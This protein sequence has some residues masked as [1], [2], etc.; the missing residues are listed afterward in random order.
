[1]AKSSSAGSIPTSKNNTAEL[2]LDYLGDILVQPDNISSL[3]QM[4]AIELLL[5]GILVRLKQ[6]GSPVAVEKLLQGARSCPL[7]SIRKLAIQLL[8]EMASTS[9]DLASE[10]LFTLAIWD[11]EADAMQ[12]LKKFNIRS[13]SPDIQAVFAVLSHNPSE[14]RLV[15]PDFCLLTDFFLNRAT[16]NLQKRL[17]ANASALGY[18]S[19]I[20][21]VSASVLPS[22]ES[23]M[24]LHQKFESFQD[25]ER[26][27]AL[28]VLDQ[29]ALRGVTLAREAICQYFIDYEYQPACSLAIS[30]GYSPSLPVQAALFYFLAEQWQIYEYL[31]FNQKLI[32][33]AYETAALPLRKR[34]LLLSRYSGRTEWMSG[35]ST[36]SRQR[37]LW[38]MTDADWNLAIRNLLSSNNYRD[39]WRLAQLS[40]PIWSKQILS[41][42]LFASWRPD[43]QEERD[44]YLQLMELAHAISAQL[45]PIPLLHTWS[46]PSQEINSLA[47]SHDG[48][49]LAVAGANSAIHLWA[50]FKTP[51]PLPPL[52][53]PVPQ[54]RALAFCPNG[55]FL[56]A[57]NGDHSIRIYRLSDSKLVK[58]LEGHTGLIRTL[59]FSP[60][61]H[62]LFSASFDGTIRAWRFPLGPEIKRIDAS[63]SEL[64]GLASSPDGQIL[65]TAGSDQVLAVF[66]W[67][68]GDLLWRLSGHQAT[69]T[70]LVAVP[71]GQLVA[72]SGRDGSIILWNYIAGRAIL[73][74]TADELTTSMVFHPN[75]QYL[76]VASAQG[77]ISIW[78]TSTAMKLSTFA[79]HRQAITGL[80][81][82]PDGRELFSSSTDGSISTW[83]LQLFTWAL[84]P[85][86]MNRSQT[87]TWIEQRMQQSGAKAGER[88]WLKFIA[89]LIRWRQRFDVELDETQ[90][91]ISIG[92]FDIE[93]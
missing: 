61:G 87:L 51:S 2:P 25:S 67:P 40:P 32:A 80:A 92:E 26:Q 43:T 29:A 14:V 85:V 24:N 3:S 17:L 10:A 58:T 60:D 81:V 38:D 23:L 27:L 83:D 65:L 78:N 75:E 30:R 90:R 16:P 36:P 20:A 42:P 84:S 6:N 41:H 9:N 64:F 49:Y 13:S 70:S 35:L 34:I 56:T 21:I 59:T 18:K 31:D 79:A 57:A 4:Q 66:R 68:D 62:I 28:K 69:I 12:W 48:S 54:S 46:T 47:I 33:A 72:T 91:V 88:D 55:E 89:E 15:D 11:D 22:V 63:K 53:G 82:S 5:E 93:L 86:G 52:I 77:N 1:M 37:W 71:R 73:K 74:L 39:L 76:I 45:P 7:L 50:I 19:W 8:S 44:G